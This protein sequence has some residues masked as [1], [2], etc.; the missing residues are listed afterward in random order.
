MPFSETDQHIIRTLLY[1]EIF[2]HP[3]AAEEIFFLLPKNSLTQESCSERLSILT[4]NGILKTSH[5]LYFLSG[6]RT[7]L[8][9]MRIEREHLAR[10]RLSIARFMSKIIRHFPFVRGIFISGDLSKGVAL[11][12]SDIDYVIVTEPNRLWVCRMFLVLFKKTILFNRKKYFCLNYY[13]STNNLALD[14][15]NYYTATEIALLKPLYNF[16]LYL[17]YLESNSWVKNFFPNYVKPASDAAQQPFSRSVLQKALETV[18][19]GAWGDKLDRWF[20]NTMRKI[21]NKRYPEFDE[22]LRTQIFRCTR[23]ESRA[24]VGNFAQKILNRYEEKLK[25]FNFM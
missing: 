4:N 12:T 5:G 19:T 10:R 6:N 11:P 9:D 15:Q 16:D 8:P 25:Q 24:Y 20:M 23:N 13:I 17:K 18:F 1:Y 3:L 2:D 21:W 7:D 14:D 22:S